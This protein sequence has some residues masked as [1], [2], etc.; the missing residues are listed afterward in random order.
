MPWRQM[1]YRTHFLGVNL[2]FRD[3]RSALCCKSGMQFIKR[4]R[5]LFSY[6][7][8]IFLLIYIL[9]IIPLR[10][11]HVSLSA[12]TSAD[13]WV[14]CSTDVC[15][16]QTFWG[17]VSIYFGGVLGRGGRGAF[18]VAMQWRTGR[19]LLYPV[20]HS[21]GYITENLLSYWDEVKH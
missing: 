20:R 15:C 6:F 19:P 4:F 3:F 8:S 9:F 17:N 12:C 11:Y 5:N 21:E 13:I 18:L 2:I 1:L 14:V 10:K 16:T 7:H